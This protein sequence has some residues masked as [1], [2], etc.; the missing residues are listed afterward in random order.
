[1][2]VNPLTQLVP[3]ELVGKLL[4]RM[5][6]KVR[7]SGASVDLTRVLCEADVIV[8]GMDTKLYARNP[9]TVLRL[10]NFELYDFVLTLPDGETLTIPKLY[11]EGI[12]IVGTM[13]PVLSDD[14][15]T[16]TAY[17][18]DRTGVH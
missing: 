12:R 10:G 6:S 14:G 8:D 7:I 16:V 1:M 4:P 13:L 17:R 2:A 15:E 9:K 18:L 3:K 5:A 11:V